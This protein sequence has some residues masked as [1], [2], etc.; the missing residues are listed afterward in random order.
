MSFYMF[1][2]YFLM[3][4]YFSA[5]SMKYHFKS[6]RFDFLVRFL[7]VKREK[8]PMKKSFNEIIKKIIYRNL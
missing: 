1:L 7:F 2:L 5:K 6:I 3:R 8:F 4:I